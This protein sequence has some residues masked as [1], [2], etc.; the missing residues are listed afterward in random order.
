M[1]TGI[2]P[3]TVIGWLA[4]MNR[5]S[6]GQAPPPVVVLDPVTSPS[7]RG[8]G[9]ILM[10]RNRFAASVYLDG[11]AMAVV[12]TGLAGRDPL[13]LQQAWLDGVARGDSLEQ[14]VHDLRPLADANAPP[15][16]FAPSRTFT[17]TRF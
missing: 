10:H 7:S 12:A 16:L 1:N 4:E 3:T 6:G 8:P 14:V 5:A 15:A 13:T 9:E 2:F 17:L 11:I